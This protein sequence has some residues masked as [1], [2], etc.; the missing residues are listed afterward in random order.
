MSIRSLSTLSLS[1]VLAACSTAPSQ[2]SQPSAS[3]SP[4]ASE[5]PSPAS[6]VAAGLPIR[7]DPGLYFPTAEVT[8][9]AKPGQ[10]IQY[11]EIK[12]LAGSRAWLVVYG[13]TGLDGKPVA[14]SGIVMAPE[15]APADG[16]YPVV[17]WA[18]WTTGVADICA[19][20]RAGVNDIP[21]DVNRLVQQGYVVTATDYEGLGTSGVHPYLVGISEGRSVLDSI[22]AVQDLPGAHAGTDAVVIGHSQG[23][24]AA[25]W[26]A[27]LAPS[28]APGLALLGVF[29][30]S[31]PTDMVGLET[32]AF[33]EAAKGGLGPAQAP[34]LLFGVWNDIYDA[35]LSFLTDEGQRSA[36]AGRDGCQPTPVSGTPYLSDPA[37]DPV[38]HNL[39]VKNSPGLALTGVPIT[40]V[41][42]ISDQAVLYDSQVAG[43][44][45][46]CAIG[47]TVE[48]R[49]VPGDHDASIASPSAWQDVTDWISAR[50][51]GVEAVTTCTPGT[52]AAP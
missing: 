35:S 37:K 14:V 34:L 2:S 8:A 17:A 24:H 28:Y 12:A 39:L 16:G 29:A 19:P 25:L 18:H 27:E 41:S 45:V 51:A 47:D 43:V 22:R 1:L 15:V 20:S 52:S 36:L 40:V 9:L 30:G 5:L 42:P 3:A 32:W 10:L 33:S 11:Q 44:R 13:S 6:T 50:F 26:S 23:G 31:P 38:W 48:L 4:S 7:A 46:M 21:P 49:S